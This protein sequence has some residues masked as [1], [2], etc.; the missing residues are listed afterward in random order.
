MF[1]HPCINFYLK[2]LTTFEHELTSTQAFIGAFLSYWL[3]KIVPYWGLAVISTSVLFLTPLIYKTNKEF[4]DAQVEYVSRIAN[5]Q[6]DQIKQL[7]GHHA[8]KATEATKGALGEYSAKAQE[9]VANA[10]GRSASPLTERKEAPVVNG[11]AATPIKSEDF[12]EAPKEEFKPSINENEKE[13]L[14]AI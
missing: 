5:E 9:L 12:P 13:P 6:A 4:I 2:V 14:L 11:D 10:R 8:A 1:F 3:V 7:A